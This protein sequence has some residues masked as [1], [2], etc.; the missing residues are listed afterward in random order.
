VVKTLVWEDAAGTAGPRVFVAD[1]DRIRFTG[2]GQAFTF[3]FIPEDE[4]V[5]NFPKPPTAARLEELGAAD[6]GSAVTTTV[7]GSTVPG[8][9]TTSVAPGS[10]S[11]TT[12]ATTAAP[13]TT[14]G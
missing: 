7:P 9:S 4:D 13:S 3:A 12:T 10:T 1:I 11:A 2:N 8:A 6:S 5:S 14:G